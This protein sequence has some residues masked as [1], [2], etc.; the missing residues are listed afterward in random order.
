MLPTLVVFLSF[1]YPP[2]DSFKYSNDSTV[3]EIVRYD[4]RKIPFQNQQQIFHYVNISNPEVEVK[5]KCAHCN[6][7]RCRPLPFCY[8]IQYSDDGEY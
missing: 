3:T 7:E 5:V 8:S 4:G 6:A 2:S 1:F